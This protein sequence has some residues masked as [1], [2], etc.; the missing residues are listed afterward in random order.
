LNKVQEDNELLRDTFF[1]ADFDARCKRIKEDF[2]G[3][4][5]YSDVDLSNMV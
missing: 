1:E 4:A 3:A 2:G 5:V